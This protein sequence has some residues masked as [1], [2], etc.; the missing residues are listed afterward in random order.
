MQLPRIRN[1][2]CHAKTIS[3]ITCHLK[4]RQITNK[5]IIKKIRQSKSSLDLFISPHISVTA[6]ILKHVKDSLEED[7]N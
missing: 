3:L 6:I 4:K 1:T 7:M 5:L 2:R